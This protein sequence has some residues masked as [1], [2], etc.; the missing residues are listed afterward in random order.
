MVSGAKC[1]LV[2]IGERPGLSTPDS[3]GAYLTWS[4]GPDRTD[5]DRNCL[6]NVHDGGIAHEAAAERLLRYL[7]GARTLQKSGIAL[8]EC[9]AAKQDRLPPAGSATL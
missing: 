9:S 5:A 6:S 4:P 7:D 8:K 2:L 1:S 3:L